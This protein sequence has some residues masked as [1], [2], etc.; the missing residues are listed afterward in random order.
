MHLKKSDLLQLV[1]RQ[2][3]HWPPRVK[4]SALNTTVGQ[5]RKNLLSCPFTKEDSYEREDSPASN[6]SSVGQ[7]IIG[8]VGGG[9]RGESSGGP[10]AAVAKPQTITEMALAVAHNLD[11]A[12]EGLNAPKPV[13]PQ[14]P[15]A[16]Q[17]LLLIEDHSGILS[18]K[19][20]TRTAELV[21]VSP[22]LI[23]PHGDW[24]FRMRD[25]LFKLQ[26]SNTA[27][28]GPVKLS[29]PDPTEPSYNHIFIKMMHD[30]VSLED[31]PC[32][33]EILT[34]SSMSSSF[35]IIVEHAR[36]P[37]YH[38]V[39]PPLQSFTADPS[40]SAA[41]ETQQY[42]L[43][44]AKQRVKD[45]TEREADWLKSKAASCP[46]YEQFST[47][48]HQNLKNSDRVDSWVFAAKFSADLYHA[49]SPI[50]NRKFTKKDIKDALDMGTTAL[51][52]A[53]N[54]AR[55]IRVFG[56]GG[57]HEAAEVVER[58][59][60]DEDTDGSVALYRFLTEFEKAFLVKPT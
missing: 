16:R 39:V 29:Y 30:D 18:E 49:P 38:T 11:I 51:A 28:D 20:L 50:R 48:Q 52:E 31:N 41:S 56:K 33:P 21:T 58:L 4:L 54:A 2:E 1:R 44:Q 27:I 22:V 25:M 14:A 19:D 24:D 43:V 23:H 7:E 57:A 42:S 55:I 3:H 13:M 46:G 47:N 9:P 35:K 17:I 60:S 6:S 45:T 53:E 5:L 8:T 26:Q 37:V 59:N 12:L 10:V 15:E 32:N 34:M 40:N 36:N